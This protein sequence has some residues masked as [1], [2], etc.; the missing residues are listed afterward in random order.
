MENEI[1]QGGTTGK[2]RM[3]RG[4]KAVLISPLRQPFLSA[5]FPGAIR[6][7]PYKNNSTER[8][9]RGAR[10]IGGF[11]ESADVLIV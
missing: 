9:G 4:G 10:G 6:P 3:E 8:R 1:R 7:A 5:G 2:K 11:V